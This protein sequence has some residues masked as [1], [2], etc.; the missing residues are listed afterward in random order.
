MTVS[1]QIEDFTFPAY[2]IESVL[3]KDFQLI[4]FQ[5][6]KHLLLDIASILIAV[7]ADHICKTTFE[8]D[9]TLC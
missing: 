2:Q 9:L 1:M 6:N 7:K 8:Y 3:S 5:T 4:E